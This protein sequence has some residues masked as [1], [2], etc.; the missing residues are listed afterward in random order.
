MKNSSSH[1]STAKPWSSAFQ[2]VYTN[3]GETSVPKK[4]RKLP[5]QNYSRT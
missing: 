2:E 3:I 4:D 1:V 5:T